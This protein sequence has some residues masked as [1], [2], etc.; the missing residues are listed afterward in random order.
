MKRLS[1]RA[2]GLSIPLF[3]RSRF[4]SELGPGDTVITPA[5][6]AA[7][8]AVSTSVWAFRSVAYN[9]FP[10]TRD[11][12][13]YH[14]A[15]YAPALYFS[16]VSPLSGDEARKWTVF[17]F[18]TSLTLS[19]LSLFLPLSARKFARVCFFAPTFPSPISLPHRFC[20]A[21]HFAFT[22]REFVPLL[23]LS[24][25]FSF[26]IP[27]LPLRIPNCAPRIELGKSTF[28]FLCRVSCN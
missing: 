14:R 18:L 13:V 24:L 5:S 26:G 19:S 22:R 2:A 15:T 11:A 17:S 4:V 12:S 28:D 23:Y 1:E 25:S 3:R 10:F 7:A 27:P 8:A 20:C 6:M 16:A 9:V 21:R